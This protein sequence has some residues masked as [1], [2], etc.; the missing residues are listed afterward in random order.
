L[1]FKN[2]KKEK[3]K[4]KERKKAHQV[5]IAYQTRRKCRLGTGTW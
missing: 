3:E 4:E 1:Q 2:F 5:P